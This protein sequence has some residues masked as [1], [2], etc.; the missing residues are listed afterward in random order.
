MSVGY[1]RSE[2]SRYQPSGLAAMTVRAAVCICCTT[3]FEARAPN[4]R[5]CPPCQ[6][7]QTAKTIARAVAKG[8]AKVKAARLSARLLKQTTAPQTVDVDVVL[9]FAEGRGAFAVK[10]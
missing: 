2:P 10:P 1:F 6:K 5:R 3:P 4:Q 7:L 8:N 9:R